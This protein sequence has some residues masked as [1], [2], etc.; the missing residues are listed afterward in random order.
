ME[1]V[2]GFSAGLAGCHQLGCGGAEVSQPLPDHPDLP[3]T[4]AGDLGNLA[5]FLALIKVEYHL[6]VLVPPLLFIGFGGR[7]HGI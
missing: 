7:D 3:R 1:W 5:H 6:L 4:F 2:G